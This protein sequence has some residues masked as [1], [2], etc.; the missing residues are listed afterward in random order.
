[1]IEV[2]TE[3][4]EDALEVALE[5]SPTTPVEI[6]D[7]TE[8]TTLDARLRKDETPVAL[9]GPAERETLALTP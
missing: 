6:L 2:A 3:A 1:M 8:D 7:A 5:A 9:T 4:I